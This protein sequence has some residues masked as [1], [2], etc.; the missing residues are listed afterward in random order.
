MAWEVAWAVL[1]SFPTLSYDLSM[2]LN[3]LDLL[4]CSVGTHV[5]EGGP[6]DTLGTA[7]SLGGGA[8]GP[9][10]PFDTRRWLVDGQT[11]GPSLY[12]AAGYGE[13]IWSVCVVPEPYVWGA[14]SSVEVL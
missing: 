4:G 9:V 3:E 13:T 5:H 8:G 7:E 6:T 1:S 11:S 2:Q 14:A 10:G 12:S